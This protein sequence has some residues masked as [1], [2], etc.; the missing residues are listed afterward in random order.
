MNDAIEQNDQVNIAEMKNKFKTVH[1]IMHTDNKVIYQY[2]EGDIFSLF[3]LVNMIRKDLRIKEFNTIMSGKLKDK[4]CLCPKQ[5]W[6]TRM[7][8]NI[9]EVK[10]E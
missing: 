6:V 2:L 10:K 3:T 8:K 7:S 4:E 1:G 5:E 9:D